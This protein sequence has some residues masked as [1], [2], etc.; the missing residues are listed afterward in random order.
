[1]LW[2]MFWSDI[3]DGCWEYSQGKTQ[4]LDTKLNAWRFL[5]TCTRLHLLCRHIR[6]VYLSELQKLGLR[7]HRPSAPCTFGQALA[8]LLEKDRRWRLLSPRSISSPFNDIMD[9][10][11]PIFLSTYHVLYMFRESPFVETT[12]KSFNPRDTE[13]LFTFKSPEDP[14]NLWALD[15]LQNL[16]V[17]FQ[18]ADITGWVW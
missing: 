4:Y 7:Y 10:A 14:I 11:V 12:I 17:I 1:M 8:L 6:S 9:L 5:Q 13:S 18:T 15:R 2:C 3:Y 16:L